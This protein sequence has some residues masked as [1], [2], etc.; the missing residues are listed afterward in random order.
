MD[1][2]TKYLEIE[3]KYRANKVD[4]SEFVSKMRALGPDKQLTVEGPDTYFE[5]V[6]NVI[7]WRVGKDKNEITVKS[8]TVTQNSFIRE[9]IDYDTG[10]NPAETTERLIKALGYK[11]AFKITKKCGVF[12]FSRKEGNVSVVIYDVKCDGKK[13]RR[14]IE[15]EAEKG[16]DYETSI[17]L[18]ESWEKKL[19]L[20]AKQRENRSLYEIYS[21]KEGPM[22]EDSDE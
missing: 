9:E 10:P 5:S 20:T 17:K 2:S 18:V 8:K 13:D 7:R 16:Q 21:G 6:D 12:W 15:I 11:E 3:R 4:W 14:Y 22:L 19:G 1:N